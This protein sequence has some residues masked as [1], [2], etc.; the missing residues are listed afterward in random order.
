MAPYIS[1]HLRDSVWLAPN[2]LPGAQLDILQ[3]L[4]ANTRKLQS[5]HGA[6]PPVFQPGPGGGSRPADRKTSALA[7]GQRA[8]WDDS[9]WSPPAGDGFAL[10]EWWPPCH[11]SRLIT[12]TSDLSATIVV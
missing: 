10:A 4:V 9:G 7:M 5:A 1:S 6:G 11:A 12:R 8:H 3:N 2:S